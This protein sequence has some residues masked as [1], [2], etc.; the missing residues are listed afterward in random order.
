MEDEIGSAA[1]L[2]E[3]AE[4]R[5]VVMHQVVA[6]RETGP[7]AEGLGLPPEALYAPGS[8]DESVA[9]ELRT[10]VGGLELGVRVAVTTRNAYAA[11]HV[12][13]EAVF[14]LPAPI[15][16]GRQDIVQE[17]ME[18]VGGPAVFPYIR[19]AV[20]SLAAQL[21]VPASPLPLLHSMDMELATD[22]LAPPHDDD[23]PPPQHPED[24]PTRYVHGTYA[25]REVIG[26][27]DVGEISRDLRS[28]KFMID[29]QTQQLVQVGD[30]E[31]DVTQVESIA[32]MLK[33]DPALFWP[34]L[35]EEGDS[36][37][38]TD[39]GIE[40]LLNTMAD[41]VTAACHEVVTA[42]HAG[43]DTLTDD[44]NIWEWPVE[45]I[46][47]PGKPATVVLGTGGPYVEVSADGNAAARLDCYW[48]SIHV[49]R[50]DPIFDTFL[51]VYIPERNT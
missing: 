15:A 14:A 6:S 11:F 23:D 24:D 12:D 44:T 49:T 39:P 32:E 48:G 27:H 19:A 45:V 21:S 51:D 1:E 17:F 50:H 2:F 28:A 46:S 13:A 34:H 9:T 36:A 10:R 29:T 33:M 41:T 42:A 37:P 3:A 25:V 4:L 16:S 20:A 43:S 5:D 47:E 26:L 40:M 8:P 18:Q 30:D 35:R 22:Q 7:D 38:E 31:L